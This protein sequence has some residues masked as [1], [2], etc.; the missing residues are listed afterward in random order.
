METEQY[1]ESYIDLPDQSGYDLVVIECDLCGCVFDVN[2]NF[3]EF[4][5]PSC[6]F[7]YQME[8]V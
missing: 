1:L 8:E 3:S 5:C 2:E 7:M 6:G 4:T